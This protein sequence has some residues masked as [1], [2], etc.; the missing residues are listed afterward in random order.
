MRQLVGTNRQ[1]VR[2]HLADHYPAGQNVET[3]CHPCRQ[4][5]GRSGAQPDDRGFVEARR[6][7]DERAQVGAVGGPGFW[8]QPQSALRYPT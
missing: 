6:M 3:G 8:P 4:Q 5:P 2:P 1:I 7:I